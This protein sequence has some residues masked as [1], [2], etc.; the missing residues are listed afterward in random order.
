[1]SKYK[2]GLGKGLSALIR[3]S[4]EPEETNVPASGAQSPAE[5]RRPAAQAPSTSPK[6]SEGSINRIELSRIKPNPYQPRADFDPEALDELKQS[7]H[8]KGIIQPIT[9][10]QVEKGMFELISGE[11]RMRACI[12]L[13][14]PDIPAYIL[15]I[16][17]DQEMLE[18]ALV[19]NLQREHLNPI[20]IAISYQRLVNDIGLSVE[21]IAKRVSK[22]RTTIINFLR[23]LKLPPVI[24]LSVRKGELTTGHARSL[25][26]I[27][28]PNIQMQIYERVVKSDMS[29]R[30]VEKLVRNVAKTLWKKISPAQPRQHSTD[31]GVQNIEERIRQILATK[32]KISVH[33]GGK[34]E[35]L[36]EFYSPDDLGRLFDLF[37]TIPQ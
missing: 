16:H 14:L 3:P 31:T 18:L 23:L 10:R 32:V 25:L 12:E 4:Q 26:G 1:M 7:I 13:G 24:Q 6:N 21:E 35:I 15:E 2:G 17:S 27:T 8:E 20:E 5:Q 19:E 9:V 33:D 37:S 34:G 28:D 11:R 30:Q 29:V 22:D 36:I